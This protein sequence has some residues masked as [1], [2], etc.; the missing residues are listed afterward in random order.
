[1]MSMR[2]IDVAAIRAARLAADVQQFLFG[3]S[4]W[5]LFE[6]DVRY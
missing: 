2:K 4:K 5:M 3:Q 1:M 6:R